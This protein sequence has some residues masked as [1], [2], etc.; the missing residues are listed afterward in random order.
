[1]GKSVFTKFVTFNQAVEL[2]GL[3]LDELGQ[4]VTEGVIGLYFRFF[5][6]YNADFYKECLNQMTGETYYKKVD[7]LAAQSGWYGAEYKKL[8]CEDA[9][10]AIKDGPIQF[11]HYEGLPEDILVG[12][13]PE[14]PPTSQPP[15]YNSPLIKPL[16]VEA[17][18]FR[19]KASEVMALTTPEESNQ[20]EP[21]TSSDKELSD[22]SEQTYLCIIGALVTLLAELEEEKGEKLYKNSILRK[23]KVSANGVKEILCNRFPDDRAQLK[24]SNSKITAALSAIHEYEPERTDTN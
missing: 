17:S 15:G 19:L 24:R 5:N 3:E 12:I 4:L 14:K 7:I 1:M 23:G 22:R 6:D 21:A 13:R 10:K 20:P 2:S 9:A 11:H 18:L 8:H 16:S